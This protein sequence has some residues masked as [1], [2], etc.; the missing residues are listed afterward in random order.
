MVT[1]LEGSCEA[2]EVGWN[3]LRNYRVSSNCHDALAHRQRKN[4]HNNPLQNSNKTERGLSSSPAHDHRHLY[5]QS[6]A[7]SFPRENKLS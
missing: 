5:C 3:E 2:V 6:Q 4:K 7:S 1:K